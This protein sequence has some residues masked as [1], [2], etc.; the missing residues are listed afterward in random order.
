MRIC[1]EEL[2]AQTLDSAM[3]TMG[4]LDMRGR[5]RE[6]DEGTYVRLSVDSHVGVARLELDTRA[7]RHQGTASNLPKTLGPETASDFNLH[8]LV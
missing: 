4:A 7:C 1:K 8:R 2:P 3:L 6:G 5:Q